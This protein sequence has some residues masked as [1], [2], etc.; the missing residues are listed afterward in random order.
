M[1][2]LLSLCAAAALSMGQSK[3]L[4]DGQSFAGW[5][6]VSKL[7]VPGN[8][9][10]I[11]D[12]ALKSVPKP[13]INEDLFSL[14]EYENFELTF[15][16]KIAPGAN[17]GVKYRLQEAVFLNESLARP[18]VKGFESMVRDEMR[19]RP[20][21]REKLQPGEHGQL[22]TVAFEFQLIDDDNYRGGTKPEHRT[23]ALYSFVP[24]T[25]AAQKP[26]GEWNT[27]KLVVDGQR[28]EHWVNGV[29]VLEASLGSPAIAEG[30]AKRWGE[31]HP[32]Y[33]LLVRQ[34]RKRSPILLQNHGDAAWFRNLRLRELR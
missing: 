33:D 13:N 4:F 3:T 14:G 24:A 18:G 23:G 25:R 10:T 5:R 32:V 19:R 30:A 31:T 16:W 20:S 27:A 12:G 21:A 28:V 29:K 34:P 26:P 11:E 17:S 6:D 2:F 1:R 7:N 9:W 22:Y 8:G 15:D